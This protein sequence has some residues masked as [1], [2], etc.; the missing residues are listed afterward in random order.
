[1]VDQIHLHSLLGLLKDTGKLGVKEF[2]VTPADCADSYSPYVDKAT[3]SF[4][5]QHNHSVYL[6]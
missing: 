2:Q 1:M 3:L 6:G 4:R 5:N